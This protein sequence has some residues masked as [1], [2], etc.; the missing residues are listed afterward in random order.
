MLDILFPC[1]CE[2]FHR[3]TPTL[4]LTHVTLLDPETSTAAETL[5]HNSVEERSGKTANSTL[6]FMGRR[7]V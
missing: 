7:S 6:G 2:A 3:I 1:T 5:L 4:P